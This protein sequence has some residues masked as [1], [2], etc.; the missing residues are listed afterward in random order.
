MDI[1]YR[2][3]ISAAERL[4]ICLRFLATGDSFRTI[5]NSFR[6][7][8]STVSVI[9]SDVVSAIWDVLV[10]EYMA[11]PTTE[12]WRSIAEGFEERWNF[13]LCCVLSMANV[14]L[15][16]PD[17]SGSM[18]YNYKGTFSIVLLAVVDSRR[19]FRVIDVGGYDRT[20]DGGSWLT[21]PLAVQGTAPSSCLLTGCLP[22][23]DVEPLPGPERMAANNSAREAMRVRETF[24]AY[25]SAEGAVPWQ[26]NV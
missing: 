24:A 13:P 2:R 1:N 11:M 9:V 26:A 15:K 12:E 4:S 16:A 23:G 25:F 7:G 20:S 22:G 21:Q 18:L 5:A 19:C 6:V 17:A 10:D 8:S 3:A 14:V